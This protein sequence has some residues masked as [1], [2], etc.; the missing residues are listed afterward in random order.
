MKARPNGPAGKFFP[1][2]APLLPVA[3][4]RNTTPHVVSKTVSKTVKSE[5]KKKAPLPK[6]ESAAAMDKMDKKNQKKLSKVGK[7]VSGTLASL[8]LAALSIFG[9]TFLATNYVLADGATLADLFHSWMDGEKISAK[10]LGAVN[11]EKEVKKFCTVEDGQKAQLSKGFFESSQ[12]RMVMETYLQCTLLRRCGSVG[13]EVEGE[14][15]EK[16]E[17]TLVTI[18]AFCPFCSHTTI[19]QASTNHFTTMHAAEW[20]ANELQKKPLSETLFGVI[21]G[22]TCVQKTDLD[23]TFDLMKQTKKNNDACVTLLENASPNVAF[24]TFAEKLYEAMFSSSHYQKVQV[25]TAVEASL[26]MFDFLRFSKNNETL[27]EYYMTI[28]DQHEDQALHQALVDLILSHPTFT[29]TVLHYHNSACESIVPFQ[30]VDWSQNPTLE[31]IK[32]E[33][34]ARVSDKITKAFGKVS[35]ARVIMEKKELEK[36]KVDEGNEEKGDPVA[37]SEP[38]SKRVKK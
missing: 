20:K 16:E 4:P 30:A 31:S 14:K 24:W 2:S 9:N 5:T 7:K 19:S 1:I 21:F 26:S 8:L 37:G 29:L 3:A 10:K 23:A 25:G 18:S 11:I 36:E 33:L 38:A 15:D 35:K 34:G 27:L 6:D 13:G 22:P 32:G 17:I 12:V 28:G